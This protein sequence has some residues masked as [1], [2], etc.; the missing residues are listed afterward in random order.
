MS[1]GALTGYEWD[2]G[3]L[4]EWAGKV[5]EANPLL[6]E[7]MGDLYDLLVVYDYYLSGDWSE[8]T[9]GEAWGKY[10]AKWMG[11]DSEAMVD[12]IVEKAKADFLEYLE[13]A[14]LGYRPG[15]EGE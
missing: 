6:A 12:H 1:G 9:V 15:R 4:Q 14:R 11:M 3:R 10:R 13:S 8:S 7:Q 5:E 2:L